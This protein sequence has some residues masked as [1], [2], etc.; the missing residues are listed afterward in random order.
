[1]HCYCIQLRS[2][3]ATTKIYEI[4]SPLKTEIQSEMNNMAFP[5]GLTWPH[6]PHAWLFSQSHDEFPFSILI[7]H[8]LWAVWIFGTFESIL[9][10][11]QLYSIAIRVYF[12]SVSRIGDQGHLARVFWAINRDSGRINRPKDTERLRN[13]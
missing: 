6:T 9:V 13:Y 8:F 4:I 11:G 5:F 10:F 3:T 7:F 1:M 2:T 12:K